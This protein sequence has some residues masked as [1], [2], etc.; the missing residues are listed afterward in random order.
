MK[1]WLP[2]L[3]LALFAHASYGYTITMV[4]LQSTDV[5]VGQTFSMDVFFDFTDDPDLLIYGGAF[6]INFEF[7][8]L[9]FIGVDL[10]YVP[11]PMFSRPPDY[12]EG[13]PGF[14]SQL[15]GWS[16]GAFD[17]I[18]HAGRFGTV[19]F[20]VRETIGA[21]SIISAN[22]SDGIAPPWACFS[23]TGACFIGPEYNQVELTRVPIPAAAVL[24]ASALLSVGFLRSATK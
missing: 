5:T 18:D 19:H 24:L 23:D 6:D 2:G 10:D 12:R 7:D 17:G 13:Q 16:I 8:A 11:D 4:P 21:T 15:E 9:E 20:R 1:F 22:D 14:S 3:T